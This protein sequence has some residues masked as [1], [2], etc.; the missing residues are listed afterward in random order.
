MEAGVAVW[1]GDGREACLLSVLLPVFVSQ[2]LLEQSH[3][4]LRAATDCL[5]LLSSYNCELNSW[6]RD[7]LEYKPKIFTVWP[8]TE[9]FATPVL[10]EEE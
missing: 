3:A 1:G 4:H 10:A 2:V 8:V 6:N 5:R 7:H 9:K